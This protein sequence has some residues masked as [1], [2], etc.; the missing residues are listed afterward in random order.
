[1]AE[2]SGIWDNASFAQAQWALMTQFWGNGVY[3]GPADTQLKPFGD[4]SGMNVKVPAG[5][6]SV[7][8][9]W[10]QND[11]QLTVAVTPNNDTV[12][13][14]IDLIVLRR[15]V[16]SKTTNAICVAGTAATPAVAPTLTDQDVLLARVDVGPGVGHAGNPVQGIAANKVTDKREFYGKAIKPIP[17][18][19][20]PAVATFGDVITDGA[21]LYLG[22]GTNWNPVVMGA[23]SG[24]KALTVSTQWA[25]YA[26]SGANFPACSV[27]QIGKLITLRGYPVA[28]VDGAQLGTLV[29]IP[30]GMRPAKN[31][32][33]TQH[34]SGLIYELLLAPNGNV[35]IAGVTG[36]AAQATLGVPLATSWLVE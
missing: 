12:N 10:Y 26:G 33:W 19:L 14:R 23:D 36:G 29:T 4:L 25:N 7:S 21:L 13:P 34:A 24:W 11:S 5:M 30:T 3:G 35:G 17:A 6:A 1:M 16:G 8:G 20:F 27:R 2:T 31:H 22:D 15:V 18:G 9:Q 28:S 32:F